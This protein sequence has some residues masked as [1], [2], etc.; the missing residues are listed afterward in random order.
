ML[1]LLVLLGVTACDEGP[2]ESE[3]IVTPDEATLQV[4]S[5]LQLSVLGAPG[6]VQWS[7][8]NSSVASV[9]PETG[10]VTGLSRGDVLITAVSGSQ[11]ASAQLRVRD[12][13]AILLSAPSVDFEATEGED[14]A[15]TA[16]VE[17]TNAGDGELE[18]LRVDG[19]VYG[20][21]EE[22]GWLDAALDGP[23][24][25]TTLRLEAHPGSLPAGFYTAV[26]A[27]VAD[28][29]GNS[30]QVLSVTLEVLAPPRIVLAPD[31]VELAGIPGQL[32]VETVEVTNGGDRPLVELSAS[33]EDGGQGAPSWLS[34]ELDGTE[35]P[36][37]LTVRANTE[38][39]AAGDF[40]AVI[41]VASGLAGVEPVTLPVTL[42][43][44]PGPAIGLDP[45]EVGFS[46]TEGDDPPPPSTVAVTN[47]GGGALTDLALGP[48]EYGAGGPEGWLSAALEGSEAP[49]DLVLSVDPDGLSSGSYTALVPVTSP[50]AS[51][52]PRSLEV[53]LSVGD[54][55]ELAVSPT[56]LSFSAPRGG[57]DPALQLV[58]VTN[59]GGGTLDGLSAHITYTGGGA[60]GWLST[61][62]ENGRTTAPTRLEVQPE[63]GSLPE[64]VYT[65]EVEIRSTVVGV[66][67]RTVEVTFEVA[68]SFSLDVWPLLDAECMGCHF[69]GGEVPELEPVDTAYDNLLNGVSGLGPWVVPGEPDSGSP[70]LTCLLDWDSDCSNMPPG[71]QLSSEERS[72]IRRWIQQGA[73]R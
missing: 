45:S 14:E 57:D 26:V 46:V 30:P 23:D 8:S 62:W 16:A 60:T 71:E 28:G 33:V 10:F 22:D 2:T 51:N 72:L 27:V 3:F 37:E 65:A 59:S 58:N 73:F 31:R 66:E 64:G 13:P 9:V 63:T 39:L 34:V 11:S 6:P 24:A 50:V 42:V 32:L 56:S 69:S 38:G 70:A 49:T 44:S 41:R 7:S 67:P 17:V 52:S 29:V 15:L 53:T 48:V 1:F 36:A 25:P 40:E 35:A 20:E 18:G 4:G 61:A 21:G 12:P 5:S 47:T 55:P 68:L 43:V 54:P 19:I